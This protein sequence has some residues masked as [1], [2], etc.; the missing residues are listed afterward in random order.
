MQTNSFLSLCVYVLGVTAVVLVM[1]GSY[2]L[3]QRHHERATD[4]PYE[5][6]IL[7][8]SSA[9]ARFPMHFYVIAMIF[10]V[11]DIESVILYLWS[12]DVRALGVQGLIQAA[13]FAG[14]LLL[15]LLYLWRFNAFSFGPR[16][17]KPGSD[18][19]T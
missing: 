4:S 13:S 3:G 15:G 18:H 11:F 8:T 12:I 5:S 9:R 17:R 2:F 7:A 16:L 6:G 19:D 1:L 10:V 14:I